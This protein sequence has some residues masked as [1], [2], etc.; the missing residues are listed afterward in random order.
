MMFK[1]ADL[2]LLTIKLLGEEDGV[3]KALLMFG[4]MDGK[5]AH[6]V[7][8]LVRPLAEVTTESVAALLAH[9]RAEGTR[10]ASIT[11]TYK[12]QPSRIALLN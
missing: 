9:Y 10:I 11:E 6:V 1:Y 3:P 12:P 2:T 7:F 8:E 5:A 4:W